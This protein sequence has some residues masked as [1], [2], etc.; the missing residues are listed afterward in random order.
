MHIFK[1]KYFTEVDVSDSRFHFG[2][3]IFHTI[4]AD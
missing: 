2:V 1:G 3:I 4:S